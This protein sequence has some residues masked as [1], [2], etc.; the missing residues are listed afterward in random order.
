MDIL[1]QT[2]PRASREKLLLK[3]REELA[4]K[5]NSCAAVVPSAQAIQQL[6][7]GELAKESALQQSALL[8]RFEDSI[9]QHERACAE[10]NLLEERLKVKSDKYEQLKEELE[11]LRGQN[12]EGTNTQSRISA[13]TIQIENFKKRIDE[14]QKTIEEQ[15]MQAKR[16]RNTVISQTKKLFDKLAQQS[17]QKIQR[18]EEEVMARLRESEALASKREEEV[19]VKDREHQ[20]LIQEKES[21]ISELEEKSKPQKESHA[22]SSVENVVLPND[23]LR[24]SN[25]HKLYSSIQE[26]DKIDSCMRN[27]REVGSQLGFSKEELD[28]IQQKSNNKQTDTSSCTKEMLDLWL[29]W[30]PKDQRDSTSFPTYSA[31]QRALVTTGFG[32][33]VRDLSSYENV[34]EE[35]ANDEDCENYLIIAQ[36]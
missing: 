12:Q 11:T 7:P 5:D 32:N 36:N 31:L 14:L 1:E 2:L 9:R 29:Q 3:V 25:L 10:K 21:R 6:P 20:L 34:I 17:Q 8:G 30:Y 26:C 18:I 24:P 19:K 4:K 23:I 13:R 15:D 35:E 16:G 22:A 28:E 27:W 33:I